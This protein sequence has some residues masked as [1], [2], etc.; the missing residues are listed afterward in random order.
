MLCSA[1]KSLKNNIFFDRLPNTLNTSKEVFFD[2]ISEYKFV[3][4][5]I[6]M[7]IN[8]GSRT[9]ID[10]A[11]MLFCK[12]EA[13]YTRVFL[14]DGSV[15]LTS[16]NL[17]KIE[18]RLGK[19]SYLVRPNRSFLINIKYASFLGGS[20]TILLRTGEEIKVSRRRKALIIRHFENI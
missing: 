14:N 19:T 4:T 6:A 1:G 10:V 5:K 18:E 11:K 16:T 15:V 3:P 9:K 2:K 20:E 13:N 12:S 8:I 17:G 7:K